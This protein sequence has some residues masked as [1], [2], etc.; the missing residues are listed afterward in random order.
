MQGLETRRRKTYPPEEYHEN[1]LEVFL[2][3]DDKIDRK[4]Q[5]LIEEKIDVLFDE[6]DEIMNC[7]SDRT[8]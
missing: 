3:L 4:K 5:H 1:V 7:E 2:I 6:V 8:A